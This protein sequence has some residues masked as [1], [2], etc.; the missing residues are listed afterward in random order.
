MPSRSFHFLGGLAYSATALADPLI[1]ATIQRPG[2]HF[3]AY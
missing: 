3:E 1:C 2:V